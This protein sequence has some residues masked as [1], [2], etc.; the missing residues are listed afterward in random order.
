MFSKKSIFFSGFQAYRLRTETSPC[1]AGRVLQV[2]PNSA[3]KYGEMMQLGT[4][5]APKC[6]EMMLNDAN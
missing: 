6:G 4:K 1:R 5:S 3:P 2:E